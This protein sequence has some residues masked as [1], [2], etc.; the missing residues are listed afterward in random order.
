MKVSKMGW[1]EAFT[2]LTT[3]K[4]RTR[5]AGTT[6]E[7][8]TLCMVS[9]VRYKVVWGGCGGRGQERLLRHIT[10]GCNQD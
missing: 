6:N 10:V 2:F 8:K 9:E 3:H 4:G 1:P 7:K 5:D